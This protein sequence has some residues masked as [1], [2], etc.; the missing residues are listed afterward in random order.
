MVE[1]EYVILRG[2]L[3]VYIFYHR[4]KRFHINKTAIQF[5]EDF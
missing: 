1:I 2:K 5:T 3:D 4:Q